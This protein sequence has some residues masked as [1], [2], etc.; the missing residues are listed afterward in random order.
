MQILERLNQ[1]WQLATEIHKLEARL[2]RLA[3]QSRMRVVLFTSGAR[4]EG[5]STT[6]AHLAAAMALHPDRRVI[7][8]DLDLREPKIRDHYRIDGGSGFGPV[9]LGERPLQDAIIK[10]DLASLDL[11]LPAPDGEDP[12]LLL[13]TR[14]VTSMFEAL[15][16]NYDLVIVDVPALIPV[17]DAAILLPMSDGVVLVGM[18]GRTTKQDLRRARDIC[19]GMGANILGIVLGNVQ[20]SSPGYGGDSYYY[21]RRRSNRVESGVPRPDG[22]AEPGKEGGEQTDHG[23]KRDKGVD[24]GREREGSVK[25]EGVG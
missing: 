24:R 2:W 5:K 25:R 22:P 6:T 20:H 16:S 15:R 19:L 4:N 1:D 14:E 8:L 12:H 17:A 3:Q 11:A 9:I 13:R 18:A 7:L 23:R 10:T 21:G